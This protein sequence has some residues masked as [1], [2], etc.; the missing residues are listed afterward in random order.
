MSCKQKLSTTCITQ[1]V[2][3]SSMQ[4]G[5]RSCLL[6]HND[7]TAYFCGASAHGRSTCSPRKSN[8]ECMGFRDCLQLGSYCD[9]SKVPFKCTCIEGSAYGFSREV[10][11]VKKK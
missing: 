1:C 7:E 10:F 8:Q 3:E 5:N 4:S 9:R 11:S 2:L 6:L